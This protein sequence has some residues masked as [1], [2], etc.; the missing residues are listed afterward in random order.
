MSAYAFKITIG[1]WSA[2]GHGQADDYYVK[3]NKS[4]KDVREAYFAAKEKLPEAICPENFCC[5]YE[6]GTA[7][8]EV[9][10][11]LKKRGCPL[12]EDVDEFHKDEMVQVILWFLKQGDP[13][14]ELNLEND[15]VPTLHA[16]GFDEKKRHIGQFGY[17]FYH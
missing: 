3:A 17:G 2:D 10:K 5:D 7:P 11:D 9:F 1:D 4:I 12:P 13:T 14:L 8:D 6:E 16:Y 15:N